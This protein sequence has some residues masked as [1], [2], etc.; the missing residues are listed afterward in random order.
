MTLDREAEQAY[1]FKHVVTQE[2]A[3]ESLPFGVRAMLH[4][5]IGTYIE[6]HEPD[7]IDR[8]VDLLAHHFWLSDG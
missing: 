2:V 3:Y 8:N 5:R 7:A 6:D 4:G 1:L